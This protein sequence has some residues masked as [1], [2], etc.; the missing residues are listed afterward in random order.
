MSEI[1]EMLRPVLGEL[2]SILITLLI[3]WIK[4]RY[5]KKGIRSRIKDLLTSKS[6]P[7]DLIEEIVSKVDS[8]N[9]SNN[10]KHE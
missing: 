5:D 1:L 7:D 10:G 8:T 2:M 6:V 4:K 3:A 9:T